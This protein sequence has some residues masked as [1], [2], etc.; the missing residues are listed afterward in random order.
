MQTL[1]AALDLPQHD[2]E[3]RLRVASDGAST[4]TAE[5]ERETDAATIDSASLRVAPQRESFSHASSLYT[6][7]DDESDIATVR[8]FPM[9]PSPQTPPAVHYHHHT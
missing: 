7:G 5:T 9:P 2:V 1:V 8:N 6:L 4:T 3:A